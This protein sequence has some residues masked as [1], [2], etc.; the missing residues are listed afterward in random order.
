MLLP[1]ARAC[2]LKGALLL[3]LQS[4]AT[5][6]GAEDASRPDVSSPAPGGDPA[7]AAPENTTAEAPAAPTPETPPADHRT[8]KIRALMDE[9]LDPGVSPQ[10]LFEIPLDDEAAIQVEAARL[11]MLLES[12]DKKTK[13]KVSARPSTKAHDPAADPQA[14]DV[15]VTLWNERVDL[16]RQRLEF[17][18]LPPERRLELLRSHDA[19][20]EA[21]RPQ[22][23]EAQRQAREAEVERER[24]L[25][26]ARVA[27]SE[28]ERLVQKEIADLIALEGRIAA[29]RRDFQEE[30]GQIAVRREAII[31]WQR[32][33]RDAKLAGPRE[34]DA[35]YDALRRS[36]RA[37]RDDLS[38]A[39]DELGSDKS[40]VPGLWDDRLIDVPGE[41]ST[42]AASEHRRTVQ[43]AIAEAKRDEL[44]LRDQR[45]AALLDEIDAEN[46]ERLALLDHL[47]REKREAI[48]GFTLAGWDQARSEVRHLSLILR[49]HRYIARGWFDT[50]R[51]KGKKQTFS[52]RTATSLTPL[53][54]ALALYIWLRKRTG[55]L[56]ALAEQRL[57]ET[58]STEHT[59][60]AGH[61]E[62]GT[63]TNYAR[64]LVSFLVKV[65][66]QVERLAFFLLALWLLPEGA[67][68]L[69]E[70]QLFASMLGWSLTGALIVSTI[71]TL[72]ASR[73]R[74]LTSL[75]SDDS[76]RLRLRSLRLVGRTVVGFGLVL[77]L[78]TRLVGAGTIYAWVFSTC[79]FAGIPIFLL[80]VR[81]WRGTVFERLDRVRK[82]T[83]LQAWILSKRSGWRSFLAAMLGAVQLF[84]SGVVKFI[85]GWVSEFDLARRADAYLVK[86]R[87][88]R[89]RDGEADAHLVPLRDDVQ[90]SLHPELPHDAWLPCPS[91]KALDAISRRVAERRGGLIAIVGARGMGKSSLLRALAQR[92]DRAQILNCTPSTRLGELRESRPP[93]PMDHAPVPAGP[94]GQA[95]ILLDEAQT[96]ILPRI[97]G[98]AKFDEALALARESCDHITWVFS[99]D[100]AAWPMLKRA[101]DARPMFDEIYTL[102]PWNERQIGALLAARCDRAGIEPSFEDLLDKLPP[103]SDEIDRQD[104]LA[105][106]R[107]GYERMLWDHVGGNPALAL[108]GWRSSLAEDDR[109]NVRVRPLRLP[110]AATL[111]RLPDSSLFVLRAILQLAPASIETI[112]EA[113]RLRADEVLQDFQFG[114]A[115]GYLDEQSAG[116]RIA[117]PWLR[118][119]TRLLERR[120]LLGV[121]L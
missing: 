18:S 120:R 116:V 48:T 6:A 37:S 1:S 54:I 82:K 102:A 107:A 44:A 100:A 57:A 95:F 17:Y 26:A 77:V 80:L 90:H 99:I 105:A 94:K 112:A 72:A 85:L 117:W 62:L 56:L 92:S 64:K 21:A 70:V 23:T 28:A 81:W 63:S 41:I 89:I 14:P 88:A 73:S 13:N 34:S 58:E 71:D 43:T 36:L 86:R 33:V 52:W 76:D 68:Q 27:R 11:R 87:I 115:H 109:G 114:K 16:D 35:T 110:D 49:Y 46:R 47:S 91:D 79:W 50:V 61:A 60:S 59:V 103:G 83:P 53:L 97:G 104:A 96:L 3:V 19:R 31:G 69:L 111:E 24:S 108:E 51:G 40:T 38:T 119:V 8:A 7:A 29:V 121:V 66:T 84:G 78:S 113:T 42:E 25:E 75:Q 15:D 101:R 30:R 4:F 2:F 45:A 98:F 65:H 9:S 93:R 67:S 39:L 12:I 5:P 22:E 20:V 55:P 32:R 118:A 74:T 106:K 10:S